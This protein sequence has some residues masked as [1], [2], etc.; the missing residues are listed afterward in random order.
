MGWVE[1]VHKKMNDHMHEKRES[2]NCNWREKITGMCMWIVEDARKARNK[3]VW[4]QSGL[5]SPKERK[6]RRNKH[7]REE[8]GRGGRKERKRKPFLSHHTEMGAGMKRK[9]TLEAAKFSDSLSFSPSRLFLC[10]TDSHPFGPHSTIFF[11]IHH[12][13][14]WQY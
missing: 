7:K 2:Q 13:I 1:E 3:K 8:G 11:V 6:R 5:A 9:R 12:P 4:H 10:G 14:H